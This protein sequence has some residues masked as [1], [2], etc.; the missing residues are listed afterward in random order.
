[1]N[2]YRTLDIG[3]GDSTIG[4][5]RIDITRDSAATELALATKMPYKN[6]SFDYMNAANVLEHQPN[7]LEFLLEC[8]RVLKKNGTFKIITDNAGYHGW[9]PFL[10]KFQDIHG[11][12]TNPRTNKDKHYMIFTLSHL[13]NLLEL[14]GFEI[15]LLELFTRWNPTL[16]QRVRTMINPNIGRSHILVYA[17]IAK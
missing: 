15:L 12:Y 6:E 3:C 7:P 2:Q 4:D 9:F 11:T 5:C 13:K 17:R 1:M 10:N 14:A 8:K 16:F